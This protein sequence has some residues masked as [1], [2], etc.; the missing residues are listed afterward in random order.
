MLFR[1]IKKGQ[2]YYLVKHHVTSTR[3]VFSPSHCIIV[4]ERQIN[5]S[6]FAHLKFC[7]II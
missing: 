5:L 6:I 3:E 7:I 2:E 4:S 1:K